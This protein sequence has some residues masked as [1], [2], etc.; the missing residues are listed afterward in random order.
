MSPAE[1]SA[2]V[3]GAV[4]GP[5]LP[6]AYADRPS[7]GRGFA[8]VYSPGTAPE[9]AEGGHDGGMAGLEGMEQP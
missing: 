2:Q 9:P 8:G 7:P 1:P 5:E 4:S 3:S 6:V